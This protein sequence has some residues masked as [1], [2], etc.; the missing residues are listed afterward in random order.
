LPRVLIRDIASSES[1]IVQGVARAILDEIL[2][3]GVALAVWTRRAR[4]G[5]AAWL[6]ALPPERLPDGR[7]VCA[8]E[9][10]PARLAV[11]CEQAGL[12]DGPARALLIDDIA[13][14]AAS[15]A[16]I[17]AVR[18]VDLRLEAVDHDSCWRF[19]RDLV[20]LR[21]NATYRGPGTQW[22]PLE[23]AA[24]A[25]RAQR[26]YCGAL[27]ELPRFAVGLFKG[28]RRAGAAA[29]LHRSPPIAGSG[30][31][32]LFLCLNEDKNEG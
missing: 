13:G 28:E 5:L 32:R 1:P 24:R 2:D 3:A 20:G 16:R 19:H 10:V 15:F 12:D 31:T 14:L 9:E 27:N 30:I 22:P 26:R 11:L 25:S 23:L 6:D 8:P 17:A 7:F 29:I 21:M 4:P 18:R